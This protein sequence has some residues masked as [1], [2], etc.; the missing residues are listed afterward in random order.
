MD[1]LQAFAPIALDLIGTIVFVA[2]YW[3]TDNIALATVV[4][5]AVAVVRFVVTKMRGKAVGPLQ[6]L[7]VAIVL[8]AGV[9]TLIT[10]NPQFVMLKSSLISLVV[11]G[12]ML[13]T[14]W[15][16]PYLPA[17]VTDNLDRRTIGRASAGWGILQVLLA[18]SNAVVALGF[19]I[20]VWAVYAATVPNAA[21]IG[22]FVVNYLVFRLLVARSI[23]A[24][25][26]AQAE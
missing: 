13:S 22:G 12:V 18:A 20:K 1:F 21:L 4:G 17:I 19:G 2:I 23:R 16:A 7:S 26:A 24:R 8:A 15:M 25:H 11:G 6:Y 14:N 3:S 5:V 10:K 9:T